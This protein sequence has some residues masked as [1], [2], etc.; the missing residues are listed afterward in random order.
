MNEYLL[1]VIGTILI[2]ALLTAILPQGKTSGVI[3]AITRMACVLAIVAPILK[4]LQTGSLHSNI[5]VDGNLTETV[6]ETDETYIK[7]YSEMR[8]RETEKALENELAERYAVSVEVHLI[9]DTVME[10]AGKYSAES[11]QIKRIEIE[12]ISEISE[13]KAAKMYEYL[14]KNYC[15]EVLI[16]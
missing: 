4:Y 7:Y 12:R 2:C 16:E 9:W 3:K 14:T 11:I 15:S 1:G 5:N 13:E 10:Y 8:I 6:I